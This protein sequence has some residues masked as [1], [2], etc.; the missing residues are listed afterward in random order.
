L[1]D[2]YQEDP[3]WGDWKDGL[4]RRGQN[5]PSAKDSADWAEDFDLATHRVVAV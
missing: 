5:Y 2:I 3:K 1:P 4:R